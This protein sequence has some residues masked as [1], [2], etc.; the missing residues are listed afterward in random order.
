MNSAGRMS[1]A[2]DE[3]FNCG[4]YAH[5]GVECKNQK[6][7]RPQ[8]GDHQARAELYKKNAA[9]AEKLAAESKNVQ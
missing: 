6:L 5:M 1:M 9:I 7:E 3:C 8:K 2:S 4:E